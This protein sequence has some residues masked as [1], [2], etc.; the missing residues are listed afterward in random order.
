LPEKEEKK[1]SQNLVMKALDYGYEKALNG[2][3]NLETA[4][5]LAAEYL[6][7]DESLKKSSSK[8]I[9]WQISKAGTSGFLTGLGG[10]IT[11]PLTVPANL[12]SVLYIQIRMI[13]TIAVMGGH[14]LRDDK[15]KSMIYLC[16]AGNAAKDVLKDMGII[17]GEKLALN[18]IKNISSKTIKEINKRVGFELL[19][20]FG[21]KGAINLSKAVPIVGG[22]IGGTIDS[23][24]TLTIGK[25][26][27]HVFLLE[28]EK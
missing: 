8:M 14:D 23:A 17:V 13:A 2:L 22:I 24:S 5:S 26:A 6:K 12:A 10:I 9:K 20:K 28:E 21:S 1:V 4:E 18:F 25:V 27:Q 15:V 11:L 19:T 3:S 7:S 16:I